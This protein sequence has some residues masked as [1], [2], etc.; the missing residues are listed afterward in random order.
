ME[1]K[2]IRDL[3]IFMHEEYEKIAKE[4]GW[5][6]QEKTRVEFD[7]LPE[8]NK[9]VMLTLAKKIIEMQDKE[10]KILKK[11]KENLQR[12]IREAGRNNIIFRR[13]LEGILKY[14][15]EDEEDEEGD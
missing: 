7:E 2:E 10:L 6:T 9:Q 13:T 15:D 8:E 4:K 12:I 11:L 1:K 5:N 3:A 14:K